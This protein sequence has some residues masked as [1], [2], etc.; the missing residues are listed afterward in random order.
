MTKELHSEAEADVLIE[1]AV[2]ILVGKDVAV[3]II[4]VDARRRAIELASV[5]P[6]REVRRP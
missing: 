6:I 4:T 5:D 3:R 1:P 2:G